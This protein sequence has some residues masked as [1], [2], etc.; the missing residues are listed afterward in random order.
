MSEGSRRLVPPEVDHQRKTKRGEHLDGREQGRR[1]AAC[2]QVGVEA[3]V[4]GLAEA[5][6][7]HLFAAEALDDPD[8]GDVFLKPRVD[9][10]DGLSHA[11]ECPTRVPLPDDQ[12]DEQQGHDGEGDQG[13]LGVHVEHDGDDSA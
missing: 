9:R 13:E 6:D 12:H 7:I 5:S 11:Q 1:I 2:L 10:R 8:A 4:V 3:F